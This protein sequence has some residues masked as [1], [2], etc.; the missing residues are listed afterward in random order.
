MPQNRS[1]AQKIGDYIFYQ[2]EKRQWSV[3][4][5]ADRIGMTPSF[6]FRLEQG[7]YQTIKLDVLIKLAEALQMTVPDLLAKCGI[8]D[9]YHNDLPSLSFFLKEQ[10]YFPDPVIHEAELFISFLQTRHAAAIKVEKAKH[11]RYWASKKKPVKRV[12]VKQVGKK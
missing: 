8:G 6:V 10:Y 11:E 5:L 12:G 4:E 1:I 2:R 9:S 7:A 3:N